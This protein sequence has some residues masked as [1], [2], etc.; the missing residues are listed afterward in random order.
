LPAPGRL[1]ARIW[2]TFSFVA[3]SAPASS[4]PTEDDAAATPD[5]YHVDQV[6][7]IK[8]PPVPHVTSGW[9]VLRRES[10]SAPPPSGGVVSLV[11]TT[12]HL[13]YTSESQQ[14]ELLQVSR[15]EP[16]QV[17]VLIPIGKSEAWWSMP[18]DRRRQ[19]FQGTAQ[20]EGHTAI[21][22]RFADRIYRRLY[23]ARYLPGSE[24]DFLTYFE[25]HREETGAFRELLSRL[26]DPAVNPEWSFVNRETEIWMTRGG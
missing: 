11:G 9:R 3:S 17:V 15:R 6:V 22:A 5:R 25:M 12:Q 4:A 13:L 20:H 18:Q 7:T 1:A 21:G 16:G 23:H 10:Q 24:W 19:H 2:A 8:G 14:S 26:R